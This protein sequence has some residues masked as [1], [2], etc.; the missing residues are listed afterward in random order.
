MIILGAFF[1]VFI[2]FAVL[3]VPVGF[4]IL[5]GGIAAYLAGGLPVAGIPSALI[6]AL[7]SFPLLAIPAFVF[8]GDLMSQGGISSA[9]VRFIRAIVGKIRGSLGA[10][11]VITSAIF[12][13]ISGSAVAT[14][15]A[16][17]GILMP[18]MEK[19]GYSRKYICALLSSAGILGTLIPPSIPGVQ[20]AII[21]GLKTT[22]VW[23]STLVPG[24]LL[25][26]AFCIA[27]YISF[28]RKQTK[29]TSKM[30]LNP[31]GEEVPRM[32]ELFDATPKALVAFVMPLIIF[33]GVYGGIFT[34]TE[35]G[36]V[37]VVYGLLAGWVIYPL[38]FKQKPSIGILS[39]AKKSAM[40]CLTIGILVCTANVVARGISL[41]GVSQQL[42]DL[43]MGISDSKF[44]FL[45]AVNILLLICGMFLET[46]AAIL[47]FAPMLIPVAQAYG[48]DPLHF[49][50]IVL[51]NLE[52]G[53]LTPPFAACLFVG[54]KMT[55][56]TINEVMKPMIPFYICC[57]P[58]LLLTTYWPDFSMW[59]PR[60]LSGL[61]G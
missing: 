17:G 47:L 34:A 36:A 61:G 30:V 33:G 53:L 50:A 1:V 42:I 2:I 19:E 31:Q 38:F 32:K 55:R 59:L 16:I 27:N 49:G 52:I 48:V 15:S 58:I 8:A 60:L 22:D 28:G 43:L 5:A 25:T 56:T 41:G 35:A 12:G 18:E 24:V 46:N 39:T 57:V 45:I 7:D 20:Y 29:S 4:S 21:A 13:A 37:S 6:A 51:V 54:C 40:S 9:L 23:M 44:V 11:A 14:V 26:I 10:V 3:R